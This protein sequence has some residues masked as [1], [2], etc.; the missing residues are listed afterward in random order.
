MGED[1]LLCSIT[2][3]DYSSKRRTIESVVDFVMADGGVLDFKQNLLSETDRH[4]LDL[5]LV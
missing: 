1:S 2:I 5:A 3:C 4:S